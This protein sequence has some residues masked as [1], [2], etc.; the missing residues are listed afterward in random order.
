MLSYTDIKE[1]EDCLIEEHVPYSTA[2]HI[3]VK[4]RGV[5]FL[6]PMARYSRNFGQLTSLAQETALSLGLGRECR[7]PFRS[8]IVQGIETLFAFQEALCVV[9]SYE[10]P[11]RPAVPVEPKAGTGY[12]TTEAPRGICYHRFDLDRQ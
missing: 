12:G 2:L 6:G 3:R 5:C 9:E 8:I 7:N 11:D 10:M 4:G 1:Y